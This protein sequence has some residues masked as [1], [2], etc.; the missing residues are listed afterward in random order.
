[1][2]H[3]L[4]RECPFSF[5]PLRLMKNSIFCSSGREREAFSLTN[6]ANQF[7]GLQP[8]AFSEPAERLCQQSTGHLLN[9]ECPFSFRPLRLMKNSIFALPE[10]A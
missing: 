5:R 8:R 10:G 6:T 3:S 1:M 7:S 2:G 9:R 4:N